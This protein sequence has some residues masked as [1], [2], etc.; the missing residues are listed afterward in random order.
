MKNFYRSIFTITTLALCTL[1]AFSQTKKVLLD[2]M[3]RKAN[4]DGLFSGNIL[5]VDNGKEVYKNALGFTDELKTKKL[6]LDYRFHIG[7]IAKEFNAVGIMM[8]KEQGKLNLDDRLSKFFPDWP[9]WADS[10]SVKNLLQYTSGIPDVKWKTVKGDADDMADLMKLK[11]LD[12][13]PGTNYHYNNNN[14]F[15]QRRIIEKLSGLPFN[16]FVAEKMLKPAGMK[17]AVVDP[18]ESTPLMA[19]SYTNAGKHGDLIYPITGWTAVTL[20]DFYKWEQCIEKLK[21]INPASTRELLTPYAPGKQAGLGGGIMQGNK[22]VLHKHDGISVFYQ[23]LLI[24]EQ[25]MGRVIILL[26][27]NNQNNIFEIGDAVEAILN[28][29][30]FEQPKKPEKK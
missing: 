19:K 11:K 28:G 15:I 27:N 7:S 14:V 5:I 3:I 4:S 1:T 29:K 20:D 24:G 25:P 21:L 12:F 2:S 6:T 26:S 13:A 23:A 8:L 16:Q 22:V 18:I 9:K 30:P 17:T 10:V